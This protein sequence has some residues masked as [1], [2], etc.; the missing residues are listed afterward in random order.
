MK[1][2]DLHADLAEAIKPYY[3]DGKTSILKRDWQTC[4]QQGQI[5]YTSA[6]S[7]FIGSESWQQMMDVVTKVKND[8]LA[9]GNKIIY[10]KDDLDDNQKDTA[11]LMTIEGMCGIQDDVSN[12]IEWLYNMGN[13]I[14]SLCWND[15][16]AL[17]TGNSGDPT[18]GIT[19]KGAEAI[20]KMNEL[21]MIV[22]VSHANEK[23][24]WDIL[25]CSKQPI[26]ATHSNAKARCFVERNLTNQ[27]I[28]AIASKDG[29]I[30]M[31][32]CCS[33]IHPEEKK[34]DALHLA[35]HARYIADLVGVRHVACGFDFGEYYNDG[36]EHNMYGPSQAQNF[37]KGLE[38]VGFTQEEIKDIAYRNVLRFLRQYM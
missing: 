1:I 35:K 25:S 26:I 34:Q 7:F 31:N 14:G 2:F 20:A 16:N 19:D 32:A 11:Y 10:T 37:I 18:R 27:Q 9:S 4:L 24:F 38:T 17:A 8:L 36:E 29:L 15:Q 21:H 12:K 23:T 13:R 6:A 33:F 28:R 5:A 30:G 3:T 22:D